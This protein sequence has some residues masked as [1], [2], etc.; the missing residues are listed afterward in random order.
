MLSSRDET[1]PIFDRERGR[2]FEY[3]IIVR[4]MAGPAPF[5]D[6]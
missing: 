4:D 2:L 3:R 6:G 1:S 5:D